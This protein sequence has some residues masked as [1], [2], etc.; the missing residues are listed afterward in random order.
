MAIDDFVK[1][2][3]LVICTDNENGDPVSWMMANWSDLSKSELA[4]IAIEAMYAAENAIKS[5]ECNMESMYQAAIACYYAELLEGIS[6]IVYF[7]E[8]EE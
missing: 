7:Q 5:S 1:Q 6:G 3:N 2:M 8:D 4:H